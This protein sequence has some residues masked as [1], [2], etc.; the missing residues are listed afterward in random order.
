MDM[1]TT[2]LVERKRFLLKYF[3]AKNPW[4]V[5][6]FLLPLCTGLVYL[7]L[8][9]NSFSV[10]TA[11]LTLPLSLLY[12]SLAEYIIH[13]WYF[14]LVPKNETLRAIT[15]S[16]HLYHHENPTDLEVITSGW[17]T[18]TIGVFFH[19]S[20]FHFILQASY[21]TSLY[22]TLNLSIVYWGYEW[23]HY[24]VHKKIFTNPIMRFL[25][26][27]H[28][29]HHIRPKANYGQITPIWD[30]VFGTARKNFETK[31]NDNMRK[32]INGGV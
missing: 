17:V 29:T 31:D 25:Q 14:H 15:G 32:F 16:F 12:W 3:A 22:L 20:V 7:I 27:F 8:R 26:N 23:V 21:E 6:Y 28:L 24:L 5:L 30:Y 9:L 2:Y 13:R 10:M 19:F 4:C 18:G 1:K 11:L